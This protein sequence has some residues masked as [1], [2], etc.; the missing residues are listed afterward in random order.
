MG[1]ARPELATLLAGETALDDVDAWRAA[2]HHTAGAGS[3]EDGARAHS[4]A[5]AFWVA[6]ARLACTER[7]ALWRFATGS[8]RA[9]ALLGAPERGLAL[10]VHVADDPRDSPAVMADDDGVPPPPPPRRLPSSSTCSRTIHIP[11]DATEPDE[12]L[13]RL[14]LALSMSDGFHLG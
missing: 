13:R 12:M 6:V 11:S 10:T 8:P 3:T 9:P 5:Q 14:K 2:S 4:A 7:A 1:S